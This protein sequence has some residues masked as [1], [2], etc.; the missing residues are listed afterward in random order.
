MLN[1][2][3]RRWTLHC[4]RAPCM[5]HGCASCRAIAGVSQPAM[6]YKRPTQMAQPQ[7]VGAPTSAV[8]PPMPAA[9]RMAAK[10]SAKDHHGMRSA[11]RAC[12]GGGKGQRG[13]SQG[14]A[15]AGCPRR[16]HA[17]AA[18]CGATAT[19]ATTAGLATHD[20]RPRPQLHAGMARRARQVGQNGNKAPQKGRP[21]GR[22]SPH[23]AT[24][25]RAPPAPSAARQTRTAAPSR[26]SASCACTTRLQ[27]WE[28]GGGAA[29][30]RVRGAT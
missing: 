7:L 5:R 11:M 21:A 14:A 24:P 17:C 9:S 30:G 4:S 19:A 23:R 28:M 8:V 15:A 29:D 18:R 16:N 26:G 2:P 20:Q 25:R 22:G 6:L 12:G 10:P 13:E 1:Q 27:E 3:P